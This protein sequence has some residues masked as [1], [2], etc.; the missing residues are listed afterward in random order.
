VTITVRG[1]PQPNVDTMSTD[2]RSRYLAA[3]EK[4]DAVVNEN[5]GDVF[6]GEDHDRI[7]YGNR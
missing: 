4:L 6:G 3:L 7:L 5:P 1:R 2:A